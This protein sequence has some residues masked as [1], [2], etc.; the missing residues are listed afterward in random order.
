VHGSLKPTSRL[1]GWSDHVADEKVTS[2]GEPGARSK[3]EEVLAV[4]SEYF[5]AHGYQGASINAMAR[6]SGISKESIYRYF[7]SKKAL[8][9]AVIERELVG[10]QTRLGRLDFSLR[11]SGL[12]PALIEAGE[13]ILAVLTADRTL[14]LRRLIF[15]EATR[16]PDVGAHYY[17][18]GPDRGH[19]ELEAI[20]AASGV[21]SEFSPRVLARYF[22]GTISYQIM[23][24]RECRVRGPLSDEEIT[25]LIE[26]LVDDFMRA[27]MRPPA[28]AVE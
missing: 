1:K 21:P 16:V 20:F 17:R 2:D 10:F 7:S 15:Q 19:A 24:E 14:A 23:L 3:E 8:F 13:A 5:L 28:K 11:G 9:E 22:A 26:E 4:A 12:R 18:I 6:E 27:F 25:V